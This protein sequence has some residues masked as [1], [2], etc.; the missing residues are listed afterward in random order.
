MSHLK[1]DNCQLKIDNDLIEAICDS[2]AVG[3]LHINLKTKCKLKIGN[4]IY[5]ESGLKWLIGYPD[6][7]RN[8]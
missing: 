2:K 7:L 3:N 6:D 5:N 4:K 1:G 8:F